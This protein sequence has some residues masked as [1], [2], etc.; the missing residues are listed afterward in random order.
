MENIVLECVLPLVASFCAGLT[1]SML[2]PPLF[3]RHKPLQVYI[4]R[5]KC[6]YLNQWK[7]K[8]NLLGSCTFL[9]SKFTL[10][11]KEKLLLLTATPMR[12]DA[13]ELIYLLNSVREWLWLFYDL[14]FVCSGLILCVMTSNFC[15]ITISCWKLKGWCRANLSFHS[16]YSTIY[17]I[18][19]TICSRWL[20]SVSLRRA[21]TWAKTC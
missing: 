18:L 7:Q 12:D 13:M 21:R 4:Y 6:N 15:L 16:I 19:S 17:P 2:F 11:L 10:E 14:D 8:V 9:G 5:H 20:R 1:N 3:S